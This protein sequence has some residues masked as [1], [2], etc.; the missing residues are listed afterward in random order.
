MPPL[1]NLEVVGPKWYENGCMVVPLRIN[2]NLKSSTIDEIVMRRKILHNN[3]LGNLLSEARRVLDSLSISGDLVHESIAQR[4]VEQAGTNLASGYELLKQRH[5]S[6]SAND[7]NVDSKYK[8]WIVEGVE[9]KGRVL[10]MHTALYYRIRQLSSLVV[11]DKEKPLGIVST[12]GVKT[13]ESKVV[14]ARKIEM[15]H[16]KIGSLCPGKVAAVLA[17]ARLQ[18]PTSCLGC[19]QPKAVGAS[20]CICKLFP[21]IRFLDLGNN[22]IGKE[23]AEI[24][25]DALRSDHLN[26]PETLRLTN[27][28]LGSEGVRILSL[29]LQFK[30][31]GT[32]G[33]VVTLKKGQYTEL[34]ELD[35]SRNNM[36]ASG[37]QFLTESLSC[38]TTLTNL[39]VSRNCIR[40]YHAEDM[41]KSPLQAL[42][43]AFPS[44]L[45]L[46]IQHN[47]VSHDLADQFV[48]LMAKRCAYV[49]ILNGRET[50]WASL[51]TERQ[52]REKRDQFRR[53]IVEPVHC[54]YMFR[55]SIQEA[56]KCDVCGKLEDKHYGSF[57]FCFLPVYIEGDEPDMC[58]SCGHMLS[59]ESHYTAYQFCFDGHRREAIEEAR[60]KALFKTDLEEDTGNSKAPLAHSAELG[61]TSMVRLLLAAHANIESRDKFGRTPL[62]CAATNADLSCLSLLLSAGA[63]IGHITTL[64]RTALHLAIMSSREECARELLATSG[65]PDLV[66]TLDFEGKGCLHLAAEKGMEALALD[67]LALGGMEMLMNTTRDGRSALHFAAEHGC[68]KLCKRMLQIGGVD[69]VKFRAEDGKTCLH[70]CAHM[71]WLHEFGSNPG[72]GSEAN[73]ALAERRS[74]MEEICEHMVSLLPKEW[75]VLVD[76]S[77]RSALHYAAGSFLEKTC[78][79]ILARLAGIT[80]KV[81]RN[82][83]GE[84]KEVEQD[85]M[86]WLVM[87]QAHDLRTVLHIAA[88][89]G[90]LKGVNKMLA[91]GG[92]ELANMRGADGRTALHWAAAHGQQEVCLALISIGGAELV[93]AKAKDAWTALFWAAG[94]GLCIAANEMI[95]V[96]GVDV[97]MVRDREGTTALHRGAWRGGTAMEDLCEKMVEV[98]G[99]AL[100]VLQDRDK[101]S[102]LHIAAT[103]GLARLCNR[104]MEC[105]PIGVMMLQDSDG[106]TAL[107]MAT[108]IGQNNHDMERVCG[109]M[110]ERCGIELVNARM[111]NGRTALHLAAERGMGDLCMLMVSCGKCVRQYDSF[112]H[113]T[114]RIQGWFVYSQVCPKC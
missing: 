84:E 31:Q 4:I 101:R 58:A 53:G 89:K 114:S 41:L 6:Y 111:F 1:S 83:D 57:R 52:R 14:L 54:T 99:Q 67:L 106:R 62:S 22:G 55:P 71:T 82:E 43:L 24:L 65:G 70:Q 49:Q 74:E 11:D 56:N 93:L 80:I 39:D 8:T 12:V 100:V 38:V 104:V 85:A 15:D 91:V 3:M 90:L 17:S 69:I 50:N 18:L 33:S 25:A 113:V 105:M 110:I 66:H 32:R 86:R 61:E 16:L 2:V 63:N 75:L 44:L 78:L 79:D 81:I 51:R 72:T 98:G 48:A 47:D 36:Q 26:I 34:V 96:A 19:D 87:Q 97:L 112:I 64:K 59:D 73:G 20:P 30:L 109:R 102:V 103:S 27:N 107:H 5:D 29:A 92:K 68:P 76:S 28:R 23:G 95:K 13:G 42:V 9:E 46:D 7:F 35:L 37:L 108:A 40:D 10:S 21:C 77:K 45:Q 60:R 88:A 94:S